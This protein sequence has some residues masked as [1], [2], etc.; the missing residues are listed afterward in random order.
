MESAWVLC[1]GVGVSLV[2]AYWDFYA[3]PCGVPVLVPFATR[4]ARAVYSKLTSKD[5]TGGEGFLERYSS[6]SP[7]FAAESREAPALY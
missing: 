3:M 5:A 2:S 6:V 7:R 1:S 4:D